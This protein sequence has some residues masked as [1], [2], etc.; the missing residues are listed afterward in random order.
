MSKVSIDHAS[1]RTARW[2]LTD[3][4]GAKSMSSLESILKIR[5]FRAPSTEREERENYINLRVHI[6]REWCLGRV[7]VIGQ[8]PD[9]GSRGVRGCQVPSHRLRLMT[10]YIF[11][12]RMPNCALLILLPGSHQQQLAACGQ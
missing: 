9:L 11:V 3:P 5:D 12:L 2:T 10:S 4:S 8:W 6:Q 7:L 1:W